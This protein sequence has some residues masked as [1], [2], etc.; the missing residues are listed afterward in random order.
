[1]KLDFDNQGD[2]A[3]FLTTIHASMAQLDD[4]ASTQEPGIQGFCTACSNATSFRVEDNTMLGSSINLRETLT[5]TCGL[6]NR[7]R[8]LF[9]TLA[10]FVAPRSKVA[11][12]EDMSSLSQRMAK[13]YEV[14]PSLYL[15]T[16]KTGGRAYNHRGRTVIHQDMCRSSYEDNTFQAVV[17]NDCLEHIFDYKQA[18]GE[19][20][21]IL[22]T[23]GFMVCTFPFFGQNRKTQVRATIEEGKIKHILPP[24]IHGDPLR[25]NGALA[26][27]NFGWEVVDNVKQIFGNCTVRLNFDPM[28][29]FLSNNCPYFGMFMPP[30]TIFS[31]KQQF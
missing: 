8:L 30:V 23:D 1:M 26:F 27:Y 21:R 13:D 15:G 16:G 9:T 14:S 10:E 18:L 22:E 28:L 25:E 5:C 12:F 4:W 31:R 7:A 17:H 29:G 3:S 6:S 2:Y 20:H 24:E 19:C 11:L